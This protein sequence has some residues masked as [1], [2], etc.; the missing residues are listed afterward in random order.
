MGG[1]GLAALIVGGVAGGLTEA[2]KSA[3]SSARCVDGPPPTCPTQA[4][5]DAAN[6]GRTLGR[7]TT[8]SLIAG[9]AG[10]AAGAVWLG[11]Q[12]GTRST[13]RVGAGPLVGGAALRFEGS[14]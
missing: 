3:V 14:W 10:V 13:A 9:A 11:V 1:V 2:K 8:A 12:K 7:V 6:A 5:I 4:G